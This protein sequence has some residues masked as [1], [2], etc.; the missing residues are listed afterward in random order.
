MGIEPISQ[1]TIV[2]AHR[3]RSSVLSIRRTTSEF[4]TSLLANLAEE[5]GFEPT[6]DSRLR[7]ISSA[8][9]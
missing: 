8:V 3:L 2:G 7:R 6:V 4:M 9:P 5:V 1:P